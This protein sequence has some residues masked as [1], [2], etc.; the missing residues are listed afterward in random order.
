M[1]L[2]HL[3]AV[4]ACALV[5]VA[6]MPVAA[7]AAGPTVPGPLGPAEPTVDIDIRSIE[8]AIPQA[9]D[10]LT[11]AGTVTNRSGSTLDDVQALFRH[12]LNPLSSR[13]DVRLLDE[14]PRLMWGSRPGHVFDE[15]AESL[16]PGQSAGFQLEMVVATACPA[17]EPAGLP[18]V[19]IQHPGVY[20][21]GVDIREGDP[22][23]PGAR[24][25]AGTT[26]TFLPWLI[27]PVERRVPVAMLWPLVT[28]PLVPR[29]DEG[30]APEGAA[31]VIGPTGWLPMLLDAP[32]EAP[33]TWV[34]DPDLLSSVAAI[35]DQGGPY[36][37]SA[38]QWWERFAA[39]T[40]GTKTWLLPYAAPDFAAFG[41]D[42]APDLAR[43]S[44][45]RSRAEAARV[46]GAR[47][48]MV[49]PVGGELAAD[50]LER[51]AAAGFSTVVLA[52]AAVPPAAAGP[53]VSVS[54]GEHELTGIITDS[55]LDAA[56]RS[57]DDRDVTLRQR[58]LAETALAV[59]GASDPSRP[60]VAAPPLGWQPT[61][62]QARH[63]IEVW[64]QTPWVEPVGL[65]AVEPSAATV[66]A[67]RSA[68]VALPPENAAAATDLNAAVA[69]YR[70][71]A[72]D[73][74]VSDDH[75]AATLRAAS[76]FWRDDPQRGR[77]YAE[78][79][80]REVAGYLAEVSLQVAP[81]VTLSSNTGAFPVNVVN[82][83]D[84][85]VTV[86]LELQSANPDR[87][88]VEPITAQRIEAR[89]TEIL[90]VTAEAAANGRVRVDMQLA[91]VDGRPLGEARH[92]VVN[93]TEYGVVGWFIIGGAIALFAAALAIR[94]VRGR[95]RN[96]NGR[97]DSEAGG[98]HAADRSELRTAKI[99]L[100][101]VTR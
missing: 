24:V 26:L 62:Q 49:W 82:N 33:V 47:T 73:S 75:S 32:G 100:D 36:A 29:T 9:G 58:W 7:A 20:V 27:E 28:T 72:G 37:A 17:V 88:S 76:A 64:T 6:G 42:I 59:T 23:T 65:D 67:P 89:E 77:A 44:L 30:L 4:A 5:A 79:K 40:T 2:P 14:N 1:R 15:I 63:L 38:A 90:R 52:E 25:D 92:T 74:T 71:L 84:V 95:R 31:A 12:N 60:L 10:I 101:E 68:P 54:A 22:D 97:A 99:P 35:A 81:A 57:A 19:Q 83:L 39:A 86:R 61:P 98:H 53:V 78:R 18:C 96:G 50:T 34:V 55:G 46:P 66:A 51:L 70:R 43:E 16:P 69:Q 91:T 48:G 80:T 45:R 93:A 21:I 8:P 13:A 85:P 11:V 87:M 56:I 94:T 41:P 3:L